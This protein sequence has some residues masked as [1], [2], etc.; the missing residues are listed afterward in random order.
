MKLNIKQFILFLLGTIFMTAGAF[1][2][3]HRVLKSNIT[4]YKLN[5]IESEN[6]IRSPFRDPCPA[7]Y[8]MN[9]DDNTWF[10]LID[11]SSNGYGMASP[12]TR[13]IDVSFHGRWALAFRQFISE[14]NSHGQLG[15]AVSNNG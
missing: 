9:V 7:V 2:D 5:R 14:D 8:P 10:A 11:S 13:P 6:K 1:A 4:K 15:I 12:V 3:S